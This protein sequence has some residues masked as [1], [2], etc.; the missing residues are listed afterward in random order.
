MAIAR[1]D[2]VT[3]SMAELQI[4]TFRWISGVR[5]VLTSTSEGRLSLYPGTR[6]TSS[7]VNP[8]YSTNFSSRNKARTSS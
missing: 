2:S 6:R 7:N 4:G 1:R 3:V 5:R 8:R